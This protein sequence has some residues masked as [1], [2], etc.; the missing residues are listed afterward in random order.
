METLRSQVKLLV[1]ECQT[2]GRYSKRAKRVTKKDNA[3]TFLC[4]LN[5]LAFLR[6]AADRAI[7]I[8]SFVVSRGRS[9]GF[10]WADSTIQKNV[11]KDDPTPA[12]LPVSDRRRS[13]GACWSPLGVKGASTDVTK[14]SGP[15]SKESQI[16]GACKEE[17]CTVST[18]ETAALR[19]NRRV[20]HLTRVS[21]PRTD[22]RPH[23]RIANKLAGRTH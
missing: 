12:Y 20:G 18:Q 22:S 5:N 11:R 4:F 23:S 9:H 2:R 7:S 1:S 17:G 13:H 15:N 19:E 6:P 8:L 21:A 16:I 14:V 10:L 3:A